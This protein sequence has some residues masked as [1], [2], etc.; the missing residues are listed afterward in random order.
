MSSRI[1]RHHGTGYFINLSA[2]ARSWSDLGLPI[3]FFTMM[4]VGRTGFP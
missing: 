4:S 1:I 2:A 3:S